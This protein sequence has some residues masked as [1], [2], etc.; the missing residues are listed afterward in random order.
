MAIDERRAKFRQDLISEKRV[1]SHPA[2]NHLHPKKRPSLKEK[3]FS[4][5]LFRPAPRTHLQSGSSRVSQVSVDSGT[6]YPHEG[7]VSEDDNDQD[8]LELW[9]AGQ[10]G[11][12]GGGWPPKDGEER[13]LSDIA[14]MWMLKEARRAGLPLDERKVQA[15]NLFPPESMPD[16]TKDTPFLQVDGQ[17]VSNAD[18][19]RLDEDIVP[20]AEAVHRV[21]TTSVV[22]DSLSFGGGLSWISV[23][24]WRFMEHIPFRRMDLQEDGKLADQ[25]FIFIR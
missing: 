3:T 15:S 2:D 11:D 4:Q 13:P 21:A 23:L 17:P 8:I 12:I 1:A 7:S 22:H 10:H 9:F 6:H 25:S 24:A 16:V 5:P 14:L 19:E 18:T 20:F